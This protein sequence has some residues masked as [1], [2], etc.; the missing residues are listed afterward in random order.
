M[1]TPLLYAGAEGKALFT[2]VDTDRT[3][4]IDLLYVTD[5]G[6]AT[7]P[8]AIVPYTAARS[9]QLSF[10]STT[11]EFGGGITW[12]TLAAQSTA[13]QRAAAIELK[14]GKTTELGRFPRIP[15]DIVRTPAGLS[16][17]PTVIAEHAAAKKRFEVELEHRLA[18]SPRKEVVLFVHGYRNTF[19]D[20]VLTTGELCHFLGR[21]FVCTAFTW[22]A[23]DSLFGYGVD[24]DE[25]A[26]ETEDHPHD[27]TRQ[28]ENS[29]LAHSRG[30]DLAAT[31]LSWCEAY[32]TLTRRS[33]FKIGNTSWPR[34]DFDVAPCKIW[35]PIQTCPTA[36]RQNRMSWP[37]FRNFT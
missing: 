9:R 31:G 26:T 25:F 34:P 29:P 27:R 10:G 11:V 2:D 14:L 8:D 15:Y 23:G 19:E 17:T 21:E 13:R 28:S 6:A 33:R 12:R 22:P 1:P 30:T 5:R 37:P 20:A 32:V 36:T 7:E 24:R 35:S 4:P 16:R 18:A 3:V